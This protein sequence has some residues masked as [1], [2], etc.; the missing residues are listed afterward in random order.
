M[1]FVNVPFAI[2]RNPTGAEY[3]TSGVCAALAPYK[4]KYTVQWR[5]LDSLN[6]EPKTY[7]GISNNNI[8][9]GYTSSNRK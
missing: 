5:F 2:L 4:Y 9:R 8:L 3:L 6:E 1:S 7:L